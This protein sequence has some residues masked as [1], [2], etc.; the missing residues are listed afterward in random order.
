MPSWVAGLEPDVQPPSPCIG[1][2]CLANIYIRSGVASVAFQASLVQGVIV[3]TQDDF[4]KTFENFE[5]EGG[6][7]AVPE[8]VSNVME[9]LDSD[10]SS[11]EDIVNIIKKDP[12]F[13]THILKYA[14]S[15][16]YILSHP[17]ASI[18]QAVRLIGLN[19]IKGL[20]LSLPI[21]NK[22]R[23]I[24]GVRELWAHSR[25]AAICCQIVAKEIH[26]PEPDT[27][28]TAGLIHDIGKLVLIV[29][30]SDFFQSQIQV[31]D[32]PRREADWR[33]EKTLLGFNHCFIGA[34]FARKFKLPEVLVDAILWHHEFEKSP[35]NRDLACLCFA[36]DQIASMIGVE[37]PDFVFV[38]PTVGMALKYLG[39]HAD[40]FE[41]ILVDSLDRVNKMIL[42]E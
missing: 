31:A 13:A 25:A 30:M 34:W 42:F 19:T 1:M 23:N 35:Y 17:A 6:F 33:E 26:F 20:C 5:K 7:S 21:F 29:S 11:M 2:T 10:N 22:Y 40:L 14:N 15:G 12:G 32:S 38:E 16:Q 9:A 24:P 36:G 28:E 37:H 8:V 18:E 3:V 4:S 27:A 39:I 41:K